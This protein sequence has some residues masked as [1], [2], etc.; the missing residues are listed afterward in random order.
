[1]EKSLD[2]LATALLRMPYISIEL[3]IIV[4]YVA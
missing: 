4:C 2:N 1:M 3:L